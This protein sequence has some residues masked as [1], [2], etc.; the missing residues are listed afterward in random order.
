VI[1]TNHV[2]QKP[3]GMGRV[4]HDT[5]LVDLLLHHGEVYYL[6]GDSFRL[7]GKPKTEAPEPPVPGETADQKIATASR[8]WRYE[9]PRPS[10]AARA[11]GKC[12]CRRHEPFPGSPVLPENADREPPRYP[13][14]VARSY[15]RT[16][17][18]KWRIANEN[19]HESSI[20]LLDGTHPAVK[21]HRL[22]AEA[23][24]LPAENL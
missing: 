19:F 2:E 12:P 4:L 3:D 7:R 8:S 9:A 15:S 22:A 6:K 18:K 24:T 14:E 11:R 17:E 16:G 5:A 13:Q 21:G 10:A 23:I 20:L 1:P